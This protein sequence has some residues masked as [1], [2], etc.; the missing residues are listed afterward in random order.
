MANH[1]TSRGI[2]SPQGLQLSIQAVQTLWR[3]SGTRQGDQK[4]F[5]FKNLTTCEQVFV[6][7]DESKGGRESPYITGPY[8]VISRTSNTAE[9]SMFYFLLFLHSITH[10]LFYYMCVYV[11][12]FY[13]YTLYNHTHT[14]TLQGTTTN[15]WDV[16]TQ[17]CRPINSCSELAIY[18]QLTAIN[19]EHQPHSRLQT[20][21]FANL[22]LEW[23]LLI[24]NL[25]NNK[26]Y[27]YSLGLHYM[28]SLRT[29][30][31]CQ[32]KKEVLCQ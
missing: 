28:Y 3:T 30:Y 4:A 27:L 5:V 16:R 8:P 20:L 2:S 29:T 10:L 1:C 31:Y 11:I 7:T 22:I 26:L 12:Y 9:A 17:N 23:E 18:K 13:L 19:W 15:S 6:R 25:R 21:T 24:S 14:H 32:W